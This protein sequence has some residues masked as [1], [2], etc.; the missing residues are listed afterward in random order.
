VAELL[1]TGTSSKL[2]GIPDNAVITTTILLVDPSSLLASLDHEEQIELVLS[3]PP[4]ELFGCHLNLGPTEHVFRNIRVQ[5]KEELRNLLMQN[6]LGENSEVKV[7]VSIDPEQ[8]Y[9]R[10]AKSPLKSA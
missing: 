7:V 4:L 8:S 3:G 1:R 2:V 10:M 5:N 6:D 9:T